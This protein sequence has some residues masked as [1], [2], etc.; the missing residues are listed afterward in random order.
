MDFFTPSLM[1]FLI[2]FIAI[3]WHFVRLW[4]EPRVSYYA[5][6]VPYYQVYENQSAPQ[7][8]PG[9]YMNCKEDGTSTGFPASDALGC[10]SVFMGITKDDPDFD[11]LINHY[12]N[13]GWYCLHVK[14]KPR[15]I[16]QNILH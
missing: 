14:Q 9:F 6:P 2:L 7:Y 13:T 15:G 1:V 11:Y 12:L 8:A 10:W 16:L 4:L 5:L 3:A